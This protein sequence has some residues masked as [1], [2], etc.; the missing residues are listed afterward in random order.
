VVEDC[1]RITIQTSN[2]RQTNARVIVVD[3]QIDLAIIS[4]PEADPPVDI[5]SF[6]STVALGEQIYAFGFPLASIVSSG[7]N[8]TQGVVS[9]ETGL[10]DDATRF[11]IQAPVQPG[12]S[13]GPVL[14]ERGNIVG[15]VVSRLDAMKFAIATGVTPE[16]I[17]F[18]IRPEQVRTF[19]AGARI[20]NNVSAANSAITTAELA[21]KAKSISVFV[22][23]YPK[24]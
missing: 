3:R 15:V 14:D 18:A 9:G 5:P 12:N 6:R 13:G 19:L 1:G 20:S 24:G 10:K 23:C 17:N 7:G 21:K 22:L 11:Q 16:N 4:A 2:Q 8:F